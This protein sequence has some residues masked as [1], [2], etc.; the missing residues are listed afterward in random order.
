[1]FSRKACYFFV[2]PKRK[3]LEVCFFSR[4]HAQGV[5]GA[6]RDALVENEDR[7]PDSR[8]A[9]ATRSNRR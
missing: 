2:R 5:A 7:A 4:P 9:I 3:H 8:P 1:M 6:S